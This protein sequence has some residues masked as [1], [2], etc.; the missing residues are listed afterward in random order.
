MRG[1][2]QV[3]W[4]GGVAQAEV[5]DSRGLGAG[6]GGMCAASSPI[7]ERGTMRSMVVR[8]ARWRKTARCPSGRPGHQHTSH[9]TSLRLVPLSQEGEDA[10]RS[11]AGQPAGRPRSVKGR[12]CGPVAQRRE[13]P[14]SD[15]D[16]PA[17]ISA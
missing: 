2:A 11:H 6:I 17:I 12:P 14:L 5:R 15:P 10:P 13:A 8:D 4:R 9:S 16:R 7:W 3:V 1:E